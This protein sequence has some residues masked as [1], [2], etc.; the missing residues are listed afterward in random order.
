MARQH[1]I[2]SKLT[3]YKNKKI[4]DLVGGRGTLTNV[5]VGKK[6][7]FIQDSVELTQ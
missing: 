3:E 1:F 7:N 2:F 4:R 5:L 6:E